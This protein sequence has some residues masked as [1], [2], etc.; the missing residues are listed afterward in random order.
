MQPP[1]NISLYRWS[2]PDVLD[3]IACLEIVEEAIWDGKTTPGERAHANQSKINAMAAGA[4]WTNKILRL[5]VAA[6]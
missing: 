4:A 1:S 3:A 6:P 2:S 5:T